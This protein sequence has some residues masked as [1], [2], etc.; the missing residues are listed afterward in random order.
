LAPDLGAGP[1]PD[2]HC[3]SDLFANVLPATVVDALHV[4]VQALNAGLPAGYTVV[5]GGAVEESAPT[6]FWGPV[7][8]A[9]MGGLASPLC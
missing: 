9:I 3:Q 5:P 2:T 4:K 8:Y 1:Q 7:A 6:V